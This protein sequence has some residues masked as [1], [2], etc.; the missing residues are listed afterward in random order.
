[1]DDYVGIWTFEQDVDIPG[2]ATESLTV[3]IECQKE[4]D[5]TMQCKPGGSPAYLHQFIINGSSV[6][7]VDES[8]L[9]GTYLREG[10]IIWNNPLIPIWTKEGMY[11]F[12][13]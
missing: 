12:K 7:F 6:T 8:G 2:V 4:S 13:K 10:R 3:H 11:R 9:K 1:M 5:T